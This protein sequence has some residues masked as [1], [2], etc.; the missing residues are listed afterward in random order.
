MQ[1]ADNYPTG[2]K[3]PQKR[4]CVTKHN[5]T[6]LSEAW[7]DFPRV[8]TKFSESRIIIQSYINVVNGLCIFVYSFIL[9]ITE[10]LVILVKCKV[11]VRSLMVLL[12]KFRICYM[13]QIE[14]K[15]LEICLKRWLTKSMLQL[16]RDNY[17]RA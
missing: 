14:K 17:C 10:V 8:G 15:K 2:R 6:S 16:S 7:F 9:V 12:A 4:Q 11:G 1:S 3:L 5:T 13:S